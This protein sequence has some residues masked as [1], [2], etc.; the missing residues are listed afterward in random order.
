M[1]GIMIDCCCRRRRERRT[2]RRTTRPLFQ[3]KKSRRVSC[4]RVANCRHS[5]GIWKRICA[6]SWCR[7]RLSISGYGSWYNSGISF[8]KIK[9]NLICNRGCQCGFEASYLWWRTKNAPCW[10]FF[11]LTG[12]EEEFVERFCACGCASWSDTFYDYVQYENVS[13][14]ATGVL[15]ARA[16]THVQNSRLLVGCR[17]CQDSK[18]ASSAT[19]NIQE[20]SPSESC[21]LRQ[22]VEN[23]YT[24]NEFLQLLTWR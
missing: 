12:V 3:A 20:S 4:F 10:L 21:F 14:F 18:P 23:M 7:T 11:F 22:T 9:R 16:Y 2:R 13:V 5:C 17:H 8:S 6:R 1:A 24:G 19:S 15:S